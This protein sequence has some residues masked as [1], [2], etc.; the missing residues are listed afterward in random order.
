VHLID[1][2]RGLRFL[3]VRSSFVLSRRPHPVNPAHP[4]SQLSLLLADDAPALARALSI[5]LERLSAE[6]RGDVHQPIATPS[7]P[8]SPSFPQKRDSTNGAGCWAP[9]SARA[10]ERSACLVGPFFG[11]RARLRVQKR[12]RKLRPG[13]VEKR[14]RRSG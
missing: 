11:V 8:Q 10:T 12:I 7:A 5:A 14:R 13:F 2:V 9:A 6:L 3:I 4:V 1:G